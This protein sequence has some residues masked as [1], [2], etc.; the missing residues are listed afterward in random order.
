VTAN[1]IG[2][3]GLRQKDGRV[4]LAFDAVHVEFEPGCGGRVARLRL[5][6]TELL[7]GP[8]VHPDNWGSTYWTSPQTDWGWPPV[9]A[10]DHEPY[11]VAVEGSSVVLTSGSALA[12]PK[13]LSVTKRF[14]PRSLSGTD[15]TAR[16]GNP[17]GTAGTGRTQ[18]P[19]LTVEYVVRN[20]GEE[21]FSI[22]SWEISRVPPGGLSFFEA[23]AREYT[24]V[25]PHTILPTTK[26]GGI[27]WFDHRDFVAGQGAKLNA[28][29]PGSWLA[30]VVRG[31]RPVL[32]LKRY[33]PVPL[34][35]QAPGEGVVELYADELGSYVEVENQGPFALIEPAGTSTY[36]V[37]WLLA[38]LPEGLE[39]GV[40]APELVAFVHSLLAV[41]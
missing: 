39:P 37:D 40:D 29:S 14:T 25:G 33:Q 2:P 27:T 32:F 36:R 15:A 34:D 28:D 6:E 30:H 11:G 13:R 41:P 12:G 18:V 22:A 10:V 5:N 7:V 9:A 24:L 17:S 3:F 31:P 4:L 38:E 23:G 26:R 16:G 21:P 35:A 8:S 20:L 19:G 1:E